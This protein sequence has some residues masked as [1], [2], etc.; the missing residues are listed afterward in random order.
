MVCC[1]LGHVPEFT[2]DK[3][4]PGVPPALTGTYRCRRCG[5]P[6]DSSDLKFDLKYI[7]AN[8]SILNDKRTKRLTTWQK[9]RRSMIHR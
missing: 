7:S 9:R 8:V 5:Q 3:I 1:L 4:E 2:F 6:M